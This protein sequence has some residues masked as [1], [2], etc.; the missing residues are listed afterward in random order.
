MMRLV[1]Q[2]NG[3]DLREVQHQKAV[4]YFHD[5][6]KIVTLLVERGAEHRI[7]VSTKIQRSVPLSVGV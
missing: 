6:D 7:L 2:I 3:N 1:L 5:A 4:S